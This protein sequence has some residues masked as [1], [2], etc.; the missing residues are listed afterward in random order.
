MAAPAEP[1]P[2]TPKGRRAREALLDAG[3]AVLERAGLVGLTVAAVT[4]E[5]GAAKGSFY[6]YFE[7][8][9]AFIDALHQ[10]FY[11]RVNEA[12]TAAVAG[13]PEGADNLLAGI[14]AYL[15]VCLENRAFKALV[16]ETRGQPNLTETMEE[17]ERLFARLTEPNLAAMGASA[18]SEA[19]RL[20]VAMTSE[21][22]LMELEAG[23]KLPPARRLL[24]ELVRAA[25]SGIH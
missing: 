1:E 5:A 4:G 11:A 20:F 13:L 19:A 14:E 16:H 24:H 10:R 9:E 23:R 21:T 25:D 18:P 8:R 6:Q 3:A 17:R 22:A 7:D 15:D 2:V 12:V